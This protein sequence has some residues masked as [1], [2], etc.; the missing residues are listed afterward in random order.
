MQSYLAV[1]FLVGFS[2]VAGATSCQPDHLPVIETTHQYSAVPV[3]N[4][5]NGSALLPSNPAPVPILTI[6]ASLELRTDAISS[7]L[8]ILLG[9]SHCCLT[10]TYKMMPYLFNETDSKKAQIWVS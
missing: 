1:Q 3:L 7:S 6:A 2:V 5:G 4:D 9:D 10:T 8:G